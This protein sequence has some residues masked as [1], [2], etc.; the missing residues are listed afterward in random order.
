M[1][2]YKS[3]SW[4]PLFPHLSHARKYRPFP[5]IVI[6]FNNT[7]KFGTHK[8][9]VD[10]KNVKTGCS[11]VDELIIEINSSIKSDKFLNPSAKLYCPIK[12]RSS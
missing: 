10:G 3:I 12:C 6:R 11:T 7:P 1:P 4:K 2:K 5:M 9:E 8:V